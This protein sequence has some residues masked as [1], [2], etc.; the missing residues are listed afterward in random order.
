MDICYNNV[1][2]LM[3]GNK[4]IHPMHTLVPGTDGQLSYG[5]YCFPKDT[6]ALNE[7]MIKY[8]SPNMVLNA[9]IEERNTMRED[10]DNCS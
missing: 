3:I 9:A 6:N 2:D 4:W 1:K 5:G 7:L 8:D 10:N